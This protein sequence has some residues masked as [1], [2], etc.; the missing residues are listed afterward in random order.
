MTFFALGLIRVAGRPNNT[1]N[2]G[3]RNDTENSKRSDNSSL[4]LHFRMAA[5]VDE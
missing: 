2:H 4:N 5:E 3:M 1:S